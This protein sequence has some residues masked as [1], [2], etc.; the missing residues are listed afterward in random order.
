M[1]KREGKWTDRFDDFRGCVGFA[2]AREERVFKYMR[3]C[4][5]ASMRCRDESE[6]IVTTSISIRL[7]ALRASIYQAPC[8]TSLKPHN[9]WLAITHIIYSPSSFLAIAMSSASVEPVLQS[10]GMQPLSA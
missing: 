4:S 5:I 7:S 1:Q 2:M 10:V 8:A 6:S 3:G 9:V